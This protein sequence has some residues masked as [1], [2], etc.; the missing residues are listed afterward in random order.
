MWDPLV[1]RELRER[2]QT[3]FSALN[4][5]MFDLHSAVAFLQLGVFFL[6]RLLKWLDARVFSELQ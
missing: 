6:L 4:L 2:N 3:A 5:D 1:I